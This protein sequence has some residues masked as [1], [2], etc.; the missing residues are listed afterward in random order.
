LQAATII[1][2]R[3]KRYGGTYVLAPD[4][5]LAT[6]ML[7]VTCIPGKRALSVFGRFLLIPAGLLVRCG[8]ATQRLV[9]TI[10]VT[11]PAGDPIQ[12]DGDVVAH[13]PARISLCGQLVKLCVP[14]TGG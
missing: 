4:C 13:V 11:G 8:L 2:S 14:K 3:G 7:G 5:D 9:R 12:A 1:V 10:E 6:P